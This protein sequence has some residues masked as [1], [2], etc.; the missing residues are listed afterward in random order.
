MKNLI[1]AVVAVVALAGFC[2]VSSAQCYDCPVVTSA[3]VYTVQSNPF[4]DFDWN[5]AASAV[6]AATNHQCQ[7]PRRWGCYLEKAAA[8]F[9]AY[10]QCASQTGFRSGRLRTFRDRCRIRRS[11]R[12]SCQ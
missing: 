8:G 12:R 2:S 3:T 5:C 7:S 10:S 11:A 6:F 9:A 4:E 1:F